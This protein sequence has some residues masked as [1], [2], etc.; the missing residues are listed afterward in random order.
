MRVPPCCAP[1]SGLSAL[2]LLWPLLAMAEAIT[3]SLFQGEIGREMYII[4]AGQVQVLG[5][6]DGKSV[7]VTLKVGSVFGEIR[8]EGTWGEGRG[9]AQRLGKWA[10]WPVGGTMSARALRMRPWHLLT[11]AGCTRALPWRGPPLR[12]M[13]SGE[14]D[15]S[16][17]RTTAS[18]GS[19]LPPVSPQLAGC[20]RRES[21][22]C[23]RGGSRVYQPLHP[24]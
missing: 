23:Q 22:H 19:H 12:L 16:V 7:L 24:G 18:E 8:S 14:E 6:P 1:A 11:Q 3:P 17:V 9:P 13:P 10:G 21:A 4:Q 5:G 2:L 15:F 20:W